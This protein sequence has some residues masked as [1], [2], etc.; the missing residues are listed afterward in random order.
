MSIPTDGISA[1]I[2]LDR[3]LG[4]MS[5]FADSIENDTVKKQL[6][7]MIFNSQCCVKTIA[8]TYNRSI[9]RCFF[10]MERIE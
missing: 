8:R 7:Q 1:L 9:E 4:A 10:L 3:S 6:R 2:E 5:Q